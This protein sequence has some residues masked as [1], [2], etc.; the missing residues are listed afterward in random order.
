MDTSS[1]QTPYLP[2]STENK[3]WPHARAQRG[4]TYGCKDPIFFN[5]FGDMIVVMTN[6][7]WLDYGTAFEAVRRQC[8]QLKEVAD[9]LKVAYDTAVKQLAELNEKHQKL[10]EATRRE[11]LKKPTHGRAPKQ[12]RKKS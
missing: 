4:H 11:R 7:T 1:Q 3:Q 5:E 12:R 8:A 10:R 2:Q 9:K 6:D